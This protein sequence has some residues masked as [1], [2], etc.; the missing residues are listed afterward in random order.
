VPYKPDC[1]MHE[2]NQAKFVF[3]CKNLSKDFSNKEQDIA[4]L[5]DVTFSVSQGEFVCVVGPSGCG[6]S[7]LLRILAGLIPI[8]SGDIQFGKIDTTRPHTAMVFQGQSLFPWM[9]VLDN[10]AFGL[11]MQG[12]DKKARHILASDFLE[13]V[14]L[15]QFLYAFPH[16]LS[17]GMCQRVAILRAFLA[18]PEIL[19]MDEP[20]GMLDAQT[21]IVMQEELL[22]IWHERQH[23]VIYI[24]HDIEEAI[25]LGDRILVMSGRPGKILADIQIN[26]PRPRERNSMIG[27]ATDI[28]L[29]IWN[30]LHDEVVRDMGVTL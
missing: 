25:F 8:S 29:Q 1:V 28:R 19:L 24:T 26:F 22:N 5:Q 30:M 13:K 18:D 16:T 2:Q 7:T 12:L 23:T 6:K 17:G 14:G 3:S 21:R 11:E 15:K 20:F 9:N 10:V 27:E 4:A